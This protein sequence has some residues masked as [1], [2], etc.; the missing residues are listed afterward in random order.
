MSSQVFIM[1]ALHDMSGLLTNQMQGRFHAALTQGNSK[2]I[3]CARSTK[4]AL[5]KSDKR[6]IMKC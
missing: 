6:E 5:M 2:A 3:T 1:L 4:S